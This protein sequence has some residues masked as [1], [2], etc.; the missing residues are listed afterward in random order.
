MKRVSITLGVDGEFID[1]DAC[2][3]CRLTPSE[4]QRVGDVI[5]RILKDALPFDCRVS[6]LVSPEEILNPSHRAP[7]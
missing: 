1:Y 3:D 5:R 4:K 6:G 7:T 2:F